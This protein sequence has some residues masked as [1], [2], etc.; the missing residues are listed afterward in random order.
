MDLLGPRLLIFV[1]GET[2]KE[3]FD[4]L[5]REK[6]TKLG[7]IDKQYTETENY[8]LILPVGGYSNIGHYV[9]RKILQKLGKPFIAII[10]GDKAENPK[11]KEYIR[12]ARKQGGKI[13]LLRKPEIEGYTHPDAIDRIVKGNLNQILQEQ[14]LNPQETREN[15]DSFDVK[16]LLNKL[17]LKVPQI[18]RKMQP[19]ECEERWMYTDN[20][21]E[22]QNELKEICQ[23]IQQTL[24]TA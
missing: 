21:G 11:I 14:N 22:K 23:T 13:I 2:D 9:E 4:I 3:S 10:D 18:F 8:F 17:N 24:N 16:A 12:E 20:N 7:Y 5:L 6:A 19:Q 15:W 1:E